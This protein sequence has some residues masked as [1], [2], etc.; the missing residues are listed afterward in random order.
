MA[1]TAKQ[2][3]LAMAGC[4]DLHPTRFFVALEFVQIFEGTNV[5]DL[6]NPQCNGGMKKEH[7]PEAFFP[8][9]KEH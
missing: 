5:I 6:K 3:R 9:S 7:E 1:G 8:P 2:Q 4:H